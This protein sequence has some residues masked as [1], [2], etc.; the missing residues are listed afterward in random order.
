VGKPGILASILCAVVLA[1]TAG[2]AQAS[3]GELFLQQARGGTLVG[4]RLVLHGVAHDMSSF[5][6]RPLRQ[7][8][9]VATSGFVAGW[10]REFRGSPPNAALQLDDAPA[11]HDVALLELRDP[12]YDARTGTLSYRV[13][14]L[15]EVGTG[16]ARLKRLADPSVARRF[17]RATLFIDPGSGGDVFSMVLAAPAGKTASVN[18]SNG[19][20][21]YSESAQITN[22]SPTPLHLTLGGSSLSGEGT[23]ETSAALVTSWIEVAGQTLSGTASIP[24]GGAIEVTVGGAGHALVN[25]PFS[26]ALP[27]AEAE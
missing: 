24:A 12:S 2:L 26:I 4:S 13:K 3:A 27:E 14:H 20:F 22:L 25:G 11:S 21:A 5:A 18:L 8:S 19:S 15:K 9:I 1:S 16:L 6:D 23:R 7:A 17:G 10:A